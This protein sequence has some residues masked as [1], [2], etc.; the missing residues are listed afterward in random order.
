MNSIRRRI[1][2]FC[3]LHPNFGLFN[4][5]RYIVIGQAAA[6]LLNMFSSQGVASL[7]SFNLYSVL[8][9]EVWRL[10]TFVFVPDTTSP[11]LLLITL[12]FYY[13]I[14]T[15]LE[16][17]W[18]TAKFNIY[19]LSGVVLSVLV[20]VAVSLITGNFY[21]VLYNAFYLNISLFLA[22]ACIYP[23]MQVLLFFVIP[24]KVR[25]VALFDLCYLVYEIF[26]NLAAGY[27]PGALIPVVIL[28]NFYFFFAPEIHGFTKT[29]HTRA[30]QSA[31]FHN[32]VRQVQREQRAQGYRHKCTVCGRTDTANPDLQFRYC[33]KCA[34]YHC[35]CTDHIFNHVHFTDE[36]P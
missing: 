6:F 18:G 15:S 2:R 11:I 19:Y 23:D 31:K 30:R 7:L 14:G 3:V 5:M 17:S 35:Y 29:E 13:Y 20:T 8:H 10:I 27:W 28:L 26:L 1:D 9:G 4:L 36:Q 25:W 21:Y 24:I 33:S 32:D 34:G 22:F 16:R 12:Y